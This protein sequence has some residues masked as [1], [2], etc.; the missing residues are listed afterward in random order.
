MEI[1]YKCVGFESFHVNIRLHGDS[2]INITHIGG[3]GGVGSMYTLESLHG[4]DV[5]P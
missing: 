5:S 1:K 2:A 4:G 3:V